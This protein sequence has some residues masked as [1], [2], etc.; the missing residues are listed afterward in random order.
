MKKLREMIT[1]I[2]PL[3]GDIGTYRMRDLR[4]DL[5]AGI[6]TAVL[7]IPQAMAYAMIAGLPPRMGLYA[8]LVPLALYAL[9]GSS[10]QLSVGPV[11]ILSLIVASAQ[12]NIAMEAVEYLSYAALLAFLA[13]GLLVVL[14]IL[15][16]G[17]IDNFLSHPVVVGYTAAAVLIISVSQLKNLTGL[18]LK[19]HHSIFLILSDAAHCIGQIQGATLTVGITS[20]AIIWILKK[21]SP[22]V[23]G[24]LITLTA[25]ALLTIPENSPV[26]GIAT[27]GEIPAGLPSLQLP[28]LEAGQV[29]TYLP[30]SAT[31]ALL[32]FVESISVVRMLAARSRST[33]DPNRELVALGIANI[34]ASLTGG[35]PVTGGFSRT[36]VNFDAGART[37]IASLV[38]AAFVM[39]TILY[40]APY[41]AFIPRAALAA[42][43]LIAVAGLIDIKVITSLF[44]VKRND[45][46]V[47]LAT[48]ATTLVSGV[49]HGLLAG[50]LISLALHLW[51]SVKPHVAV[52]GKVDGNAGEE[53]YRNVDRYATEPVP[54]VIMVRPDAPLFFANI[55]YLEN[56]LL[57][58]LA[59]QREARYIIID[60]SGIN[61]IDSSA[62]ESLRQFAD[63]IRKQGCELF[64]TSLKG[65]VRDVMKSADFYAFLGQDHCFE[66][67]QTA[68]RAIEKDAT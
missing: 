42:V 41:L 50:V 58:L 12:G 10:R 63:N 29:I 35:Y 5:T 66:T 11:A 26:H 22:A 33:I 8:S 36:A 32:V 31:I 15:R 53:L 3:A 18:P 2:F 55:R 49:E 30:L 39:L 40:I 45:G 51:Q 4:G 7:L 17:F 62:L 59:E 19:D 47:L 1:A 65:P 9:L 27:V 34:G 68:L 24:A 23:P 56:K 48:F 38:T 6:T 64:M 25:W 20:I 21:L 16:F 61:D 60:G 28:R 13:G 57:T 54:H 52:L 37:G 43:I 67:V 46:Y 44:H 14:G